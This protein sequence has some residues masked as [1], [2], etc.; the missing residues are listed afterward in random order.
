MDRPGLRQVLEGSGELVAKSFVVP[1]EIHCLYLSGGA[2]TTLAVKG[3]MMMMSA[4]FRTPGC[5][6]VP[7]VL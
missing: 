6:F 2:P 7:Y 3:L 4:N 5:L 1:T